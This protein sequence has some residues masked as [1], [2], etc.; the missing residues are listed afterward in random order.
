M[1]YRQFHHVS[2]LATAAAFFLP[3]AASFAGVDEEARRLYK[4]NCALCHGADGRART[5]IARI[6][7]VKDLTQGKI[8]DSEIERQVTIGSK[9]PDGKEKMPA[10]GMKLTPEQI[11]SLIPVV[12]EF[13]N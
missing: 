3:V 7:G 13:R 6:L 8:S 4:M 10:F 2:L 1:L 9:G 12:K 11:Q 5:P